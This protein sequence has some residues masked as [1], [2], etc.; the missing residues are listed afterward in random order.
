MG[1][2]TDNIQQAYKKLDAFRQTIENH[3]FNY[4]GHVIKVTMT[5]GLAA[6]ES[7]MTGDN[8]FTCVDQKL[9]DGKHSGKNKVVL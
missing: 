7:G 6:Y 5:I 4:K 8:W 1:K 3:S 2:T 9:Y